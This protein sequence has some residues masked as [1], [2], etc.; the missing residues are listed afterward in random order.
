MLDLG[1][2][3]SLQSAV[4]IEHRDMTRTSPD[5]LDRSTREAWRKYSTATL[6]KIYNRWV[7]CLDHIIMLC[8]DNGKID[9]LRG[10]LVIPLVMGRQPN[11]AAM[12]GNDVG[13]D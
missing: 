8:G 11:R 12:D 13:E 2:W 3:A 1:V 10:D 5:A 9:K 7:L 4:E 6:L